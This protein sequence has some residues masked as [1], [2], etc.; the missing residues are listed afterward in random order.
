MTKRKPELRPEYKKKLR[1][2]VF[3]LVALVGLLGGSI[4][5]MSS[6]AFVSAASG[7][8][9]PA[10]EG[11]RLTI[12]EQEYSP[13]QTGI[14]FNLHWQ[15]PEVTPASYAIFIKPPGANQFYYGTTPNVFTDGDESYGSLPL[16]N[17]NKGDTG[18]WSGSWYYS[19]ATEEVTGFTFS[20]G[21]EISVAIF[22]LG[23]GYG[24]YPEYTASG[25]KPTYAELASFNRSI[26]TFNVALDDL[27]DD[28][29]DPYDPITGLEI[30]QTSTSVTASWD[31]LPDAVNTDDVDYHVYIKKEGASTWT[32]TA[33]TYWNS[34]T[35]TSVDIAVASQ[36]CASGLCYAQYGTENNGSGTYGS[37]ADG[38]TFDIAVVPESRFE[39]DH[40]TYQT[41]YPLYTD[42]DHSAQALNSFTYG[43]NS[44]GGGNGGNNG[45]GGGSGGN[46]GGGG[47]GGG[48][49]NNG[50]GGS[51]GGSNSGGGDTPVS[52]VPGAVKTTVKFE[53]KKPNDAA[54]I[55][56][57]E[58]A[59]LSGERGAVNVQQGA[60]LKGTGKA[61]SIDVKAGATVAPGNSP[62]TLTVLTTFNLSGT[63]EAE[64]LNKNTY[65]Q[66]K[67]G[68]DFS[69]S[70]NAVTLANGAALD[71]DLY[72][73]WNIDA[74]DK[75][76][77]IDN[78][79]D[80]DVSGTFDGIA[81]GSTVTVGSMA[82]TIS[83]EGGDG[84]DV[85]LTATTS[86]EGAAGEVSSED[87][88]TPLAP[89]TAI[90]P[91]V[92]KSPIMT[93]ISTLVVIVS[94]ASL[95][96]LFHSKAR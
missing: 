86:G 57:K 22:A 47:S 15:T 65:D 54:T 30:E 14:I 68:E 3:S 93:L 27:W 6:V 58:V 48:G 44:T 8:P 85:V 5:T 16:N 19:D 41:Y 20:E 4:A 74:G 45:G 70:G 51:G 56:D 46:N 24:M 18:P 96:R 1:Q 69:G 42:L 13:T 80:T 75:F 29:G 63:Y 72:S 33:N 7:D 94:F 37:I 76:T 88:E 87:G 64:V 50:G 66:L 2:Q 35:P 77:I 11:L 95:L 26:F 49:S 59:T 89:N 53:D 60:T 9:F 12:D 39:R 83:Y 92:F 90:G 91:L 62:G 40:K 84:N 79:S 25:S 43:D 23:A 36:N 71:V 82:F 81:E 34:Q 78:Q 21:S 38:D 52:N 55:A 67:V 28:A 73:G 10:V 61:N 31:S 17:V 32:L